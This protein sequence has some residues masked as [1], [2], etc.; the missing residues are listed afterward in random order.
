MVIEV[1]GLRCWWPG[2]IQALYG[3]REGV[4][5]LGSYGMGGGGGKDR[6]VT[7]KGGAGKK[8]RGR[9]DE[10]VGLE[11]AAVTKADD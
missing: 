6:I 5:R 11:V 2:Y 1:A 4:G 9:P 7:G 3:C 10:A 8:A